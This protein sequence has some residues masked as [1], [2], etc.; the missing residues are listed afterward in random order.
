MAKLLTRM[1]VQNGSS[2]KTISRARR[3]GVC[4]ARWYAIG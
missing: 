3:R 2:T 4:F 1:L